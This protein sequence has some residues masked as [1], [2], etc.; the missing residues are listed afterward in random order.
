MNERIYKILKNSGVWSIV[1][2]IVI[3]AAGISVGVGCIVNGGVLLK[4]KSDIT[5]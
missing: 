4:R 2:G 5:F 3:L 1:M